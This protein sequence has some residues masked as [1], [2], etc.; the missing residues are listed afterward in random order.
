[1]LRKSWTK[2]VPRV[3]VASCL[4]IGALYVV[5]GPGG[6]NG[7]VSQRDLAE[8]HEDKILGRKND[9]TKYILYATSFFR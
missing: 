3:T 7:I 2:A 9:R 6:D 1:M 5:I 4:V 8:K